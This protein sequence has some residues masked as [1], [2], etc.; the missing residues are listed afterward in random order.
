MACLWEEAKL[1][2]STDR[3]DNVIWA[4]CKLSIGTDGDLNSL[5]GLSVDS[6]S[7]NRKEAEK[8]V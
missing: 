5:S 3:S 1:Y 4:V 6:S 8:G 2:L 7:G